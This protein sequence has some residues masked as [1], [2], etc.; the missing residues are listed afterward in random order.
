MTAGTRIKTRNIVSP[1]LDV[2]LPYYG[3]VSYMKLAVESVLAQNL[4]TWRLVVIDDGYPDPEPARWIGEL[5]ARDPRVEYFRN[6][7]NLGANGNYR[8]A[9]TLVRA[10]Y[11]VMM[12]ADD[13]MLPNFV[14]S[15][16]DL[17][18]S[19][20]EA[21]VIQP[22]VAVI[23]KD[24][25]RYT[26]LADRVKSWY[27]PRTETTLS[28]EDMARSLV[29]A[30]WAYFPS[31]VWRTAAVRAQGFRQGLDV[32][33]DLALLLDIAVSGGAMA[34]GKTTA[35]EY[36]RH[37]SSDSSV[38]AFD[39]RRFAEERDFLDQQ[40]E[41]FKAMGWERASRAA[42]GRLAPRLHAASVALRAA[43]RGELR[44]SLHLMGFVFAR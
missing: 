30:D 10:D 19:Y 13:L 24:G 27:A 23:D 35:F 36:R 14:S 7:T 32:V 41:R 28:G 37:A 34:I 26:P 6:E 38:R 29:R 9:L 4:D 31:I 21:D 11:F 22:G 42:R 16:M 39:G 8:K 40:A 43:S 25:K 20:P 3:D 15:V 2:M 17:I 18:T 1:T 44:A 5:S 12:G 33:Q